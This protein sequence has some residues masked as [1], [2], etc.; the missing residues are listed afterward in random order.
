MRTHGEK[1]KRFKDEVEHSQQLAHDLGACCEVEQFVLNAKVK[2]PTG[3]M[4]R[5]KLAVINRADFT[6]TSDSSTSDDIDFESTLKQ[7]PR[8]IVPS[9]ANSSERGL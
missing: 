4:R 7:S 3:S 2:G 1:I 5:I 9:P 8:V 6:K